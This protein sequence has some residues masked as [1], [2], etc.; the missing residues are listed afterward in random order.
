MKMFLTR[1]GANSKA[2]ITGDTTQ[3]DLPTGSRSGLI[4]VQQILTHI[5]AIKF[6][7]FTEQDVVRHA[8]VQEIINAYDGYESSVQQ[9]FQLDAGEAK[10]PE[11]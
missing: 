8:L 7:H 2:V 10:E 3:V 1:L 5:E 4:H 6:V 9:E 11:S